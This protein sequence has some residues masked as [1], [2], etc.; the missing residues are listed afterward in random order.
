[1]NAAN[2]IDK[3]KVFNALKN[4]E[5]EAQNKM[6]VFQKKIDNLKKDPTDAQLRK[7]Y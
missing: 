1:M 3:E 5:N 2:E 7:L 6:E 4:Y